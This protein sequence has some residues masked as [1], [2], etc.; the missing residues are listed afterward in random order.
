MKKLLICFLVGLSITTCGCKSNVN[1]QETLPKT[2]MTTSPESKNTVPK[3]S[4]NGSTSTETTQKAFTV[5]ELV[6]Y[7]GQNGNPAYIAV[8]GMV[9]DVTYAPDW[10]NGIHKNGYVA[11]SNL[12]SVIDSFPNGRDALRDLPI[13]GTL[14]Y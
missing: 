14:K 8:D 6:V 13:I 12:S 1:K 5:E 4:G 11:G 2:P 10:K 7:N 3:A 9:Y